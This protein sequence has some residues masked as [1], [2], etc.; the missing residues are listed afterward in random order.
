MR[1]AVMYG[2]QDVRVESV[3]DAELVDPTDALITITHSGI[4]GS[5]LWPYNLM[6]PGEAARPMGH[7]AMGIVSAIG[8]RGLPD[9]LAPGL[10]HADALQ[11][12]R[13]GGWPIWST[14]TTTNEF[15]WFPEAGT[16]S[17]RSC[18]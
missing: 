4:C 1:A 17:L 15:A 14:A 3:P 16:A 2:Q 10:C 18:D 7:E 9:R 6:E 8:S 13:T 5:D 11:S 12:G